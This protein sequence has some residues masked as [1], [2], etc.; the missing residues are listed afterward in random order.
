MVMV[1]IYNIS[2]N[3]TKNLIVTAKR[4]SLDQNQ[5]QHVFLNPEN[6]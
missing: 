1:L 3:G 5:F 6:K 4:L 2:M